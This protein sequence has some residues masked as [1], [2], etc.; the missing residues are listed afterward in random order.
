MFKSLWG[1]VNKDGG[2]KLLQHILPEMQATGYHGIE[3]SVRL[4]YSLD[5]SDGFAALMKEHG[6]RWIPIVF[7][8]GPDAVVNS[9]TPIIDHDSSVER[10]VDTIKQQIAI[11]MSMSAGMEVPFIN[12]HTGHDSFTEIKAHTLLQRL[13]RAEDE[14]SVKIVHEVHRGRIFFNPWVTQRLAQ[15]NPNVKLIAD[16]S[17]F[18]CASE[19]E[20]WDPNLIR[21]LDRLAPHIHHIHA[22]IGYDN[23]PQVVD[24]RFPTWQRHTRAFESLWKYIW[25]VQ[26]LN[27]FRSTS[28]TTEFGPPSYQPVYPCICK[29]SVGLEDINEWM[30]RR[31]QQVFHEAVTDS[32]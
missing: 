18:T 6:L 22:R 12:S 8:S 13:A 25:K 26:Y 7:S 29:S 19:I 11:A 23:G 32:V 10:H 27:G 5:K 17:H 9:Q 1:L 4:A 3:C 14:L 20:P 24:P 30:G 21:V 15:Q 28:A 31:V 2:N 16:Y